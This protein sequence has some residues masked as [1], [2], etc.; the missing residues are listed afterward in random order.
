MNSSGATQDCQSMILN[1]VIHL[2]KIAKHSA[3]KPRRTELSVNSIK[4]YLTG[5]KSFLPRI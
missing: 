4:L 3:G 2:K 5:V 1:Y